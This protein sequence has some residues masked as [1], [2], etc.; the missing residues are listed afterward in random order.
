MNTLRHDFMKYVSSNVLGMLAISLYV[1]ADT[2]FISACLGSNGLASLNIA[3]PVYNLMSAFAL[4]LGIGSA[5]RFTILH[6]QKRNAKASSLFSFTFLFG[7]L[8]G[9]LLCMTGILFSEDIASILGANGEILPTTTLYLKTIL[10]FAPFFIL[11]NI[12]IAYLRNDNDPKLAMSGMLIGSLSNIILDYVFMYPLNWGIFGAAFATELAPI[13]SLC[14]L[15]IHFFKKTNSLKFVLKDLK[16]SY[17]KTIF[18]LGLS[19]FINEFSS[20][21]VLIVFNFL[22]LA[23]AGNIAV[24]AYGIIANLSLVSIA[25]FTGISQGCQPLISR[26]YGKKETNNINHL[27]KLSL[28]VSFIVSILLILLVYLFTGDIIAIFNSE[29]NQTLA[30][31]ASDGLRIYFL[32]FLF[33]G[34][35]I[36]TISWL[37]A[38]EKSKYSSILA[39]FRGFFGIILCAFLLSICFGITGIWLAF[40]VCELFC[41]LLA[42]FYLWHIKKNKQV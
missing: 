38:I 42:I 19:S 25:I 40:P 14:I 29:N 31:F 16:I 21:I 20:G 7:T 36:S 34:I 30:N 39:L 11:N 3:I 33:T 12:M 41:A 22:L 1:L 32:G 2:Y 37:A 35:N 10:C 4:L 26:C 23:Q 28:K 6:S 13:I 27:L 15:S 17:L 9:I 18:T 5:T 24:A 8:S